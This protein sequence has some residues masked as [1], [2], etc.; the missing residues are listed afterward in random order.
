MPRKKATDP[1]IEAEAEPTVEPFE[2][3]IENAF[4]FDTPTDEERQQDEREA[5]EELMRNADVPE[6]ADEV[7]FNKTLYER[8]NDD[9]SHEGNRAMRQERAQTIGTYNSARKTRTILTGKIAT[10][11]PGRNTAYWIC[12]DGPMTIRIPCSETFFDLPES[13]SRNDRN[14]VTDKVNFLTKNIGATISFVLTSVTGTE[15][16]ASRKLAMQRIRSRY[17]G[18]GAVNPV[19]V[20]DIVTAQFVSVGQHAAFLHVNGVDVRVR[21][22]DISHRYIPL[23]DAVYA[24]GDMIKVKVTDLR[25][26]HLT[27]ENGSNGLRPVLSV[28]GAAAEMEEWPS[29]Y[30]RVKAGLKCKATVKSVTLQKNE[31][32][33]HITLFLDDIGL[34]AFS[35]TAV[36]NI[37]DKLHTGD[38]VVFEINGISD[39]SGMV[40]GTI[41]RMVNR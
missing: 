8:K 26:E 16:T 33:L 21:K 1:I 10:V 5:R 35:N 17:F 4:D 13:F 20:G 15:A 14:T 23:V 6:S 27:G 19:R 24:P 11:E 22:A 7:R 38:S 2:T 41:V 9:E 37:R 12:Y 3:P 32:K 40:H 28:S 36:L 29:F 39:Q 34:P 30:S 31:T 18:N 25:Y